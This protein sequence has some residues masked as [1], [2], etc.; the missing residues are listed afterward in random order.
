MMN[1]KKWIYAVCCAALLLGCKP[2]VEDIEK[3]PDTMQKS[4][5]RGV[6]FN[7]N[8]IEDFLLL[9]PSVSWSY[10]WGNTQNEDAAMCFDAEGMD[11]CPMIWNNDYNPNAIRNYVAMHP[12]TQYLLAYN[13]PNLTDQASMTPAQAA[14][15]WGNVV[16]LA[17]ELNLKLVS[18]AMN[19]GTLAGY[20]DPI[21]WLDEFFAQPNVSID[22]IDA[23]SVHCYMPSVSALQGYIEKFRKYN[24]PVWLTEFCAWDGMGDNVENQLNYMTAALNYLEQEELVARYAWFM[25]RTSKPVDSYPYQQL[26]THTSPVAFTPLGR[27]FADFSTFDKKAY[28]PLCKTV[29]AHQYVWLSNNGIPM[30]VAEDDQL[31]IAGLQ[32]GT[33]LDYQLLIQPDKPLQITYASITHA[34]VCVYVDGVAQAII[35]LPKTA[36]MQTVATYTTDFVPETGNHTL[37]LEMLNGSMYYYSI[38]Q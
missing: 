4:P 20:S 8:S 31:Y 37:R 2:T 29:R 38:A 32:A 6:C 24:K 27:I 7:F 11:F 25:P 16:A 18:P 34:Q 33:W 3:H 1:S 14:A 13:E 5:K 19:Y 12:N 22:D 23:I 28:L 36:D 17:K 35:D 15:Q 30:R 9:S 21:K 10:N 26:L